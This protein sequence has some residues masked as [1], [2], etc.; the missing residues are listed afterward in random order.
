MTKTLMQTTLQRQ[1]LLLRRT[2]WLPSLLLRGHCQE[3]S[4]PSSLVSLV[5]MIS[6]GP[7]IESHLENPSSQAALTVA[8]LLQF[9][10]YFRR[11]ET[12]SNCDRHSK[13]RETPVPLYV[14]L[15]VHAQTAKRELVDTLFK[16][17]ISY[18]HVLGISTEIGNYVCHRWC[19]VPH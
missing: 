2:C 7:N 10:C 18:D 17:G 19:L 6:Y 11:R 15:T 9:N 3:N 16:S 1:P 13:N 14:G 4:V 5:K 12:N 8:Q